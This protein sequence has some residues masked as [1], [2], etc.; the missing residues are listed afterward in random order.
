MDNVYAYLVPLPA[1]IHE[2]VMPCFDGFTV[3]INDSLPLEQREKA[4]RHAVKHIVEKDFEKHDVQEI[5]LI[6]TNKE[7]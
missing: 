2:M 6:H 4:Y 5:E 3:Y 7:V 1:G